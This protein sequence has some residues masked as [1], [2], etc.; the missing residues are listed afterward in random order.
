MPTRLL[1]LARSNLYRAAWQALLEKQPGI[2]VVGA[3][4]EI[5][6]IQANTQPAQNTAVL[7]D[8]PKPQAEY[9]RRLREAR[10]GNGLLFLLESF[11]LAEVV[12]L[13]QA[14]ATG[15]ILRDAQVGDLA[16]AV[17]ATGRAEIVLPP[18]LAARALAAL[19]RGQVPREEPAVSLTEREQEVLGLLANGLTNKDIAQTLILSVRT[20]EAH[21]RNVYS[22]LD[23][24]SRTEA[25]LWAVHN[26][27]GNEDPAG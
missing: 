25:A 8:I 2:V 3:F 13:L 4:D 10:L 5:D 22:K 14:G 20:V 16:R 26:G 9:V 12:S 7:V 11:D 23:V 27:Y 18:P 1:I 6:R 15:F 17:I 19:A 24:S 21:L